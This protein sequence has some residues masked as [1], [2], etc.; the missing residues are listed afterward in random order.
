M[1]DQRT[2]INMLIV[3]L[4]DC[5]SNTQKLFWIHIWSWSGQCSGHANFAILQFPPAKIQQTMMAVSRKAETVGEVKCICVFCECFLLCIA[6]KYN[7]NAWQ[8]FSIS[9]I[10]QL[11]QNFILMPSTVKLPAG[12]CLGQGFSDCLWRGNLMLWP[13]KLSFSQF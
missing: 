13:I 3:C 12:D 2:I 1:A 10:T 5:V 8:S 4:Q 6:I 11:N 7:K 9:R